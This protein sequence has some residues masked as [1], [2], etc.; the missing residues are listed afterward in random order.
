MERNYPT[1]ISLAAERYTVKIKRRAY[2]ATSP[3]DV[4]CGFVQI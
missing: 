2:A 3:T 1:P 4:S